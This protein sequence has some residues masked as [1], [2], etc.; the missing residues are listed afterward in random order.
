MTDLS[1]D[2]FIRMYTSLP[3]MPYSINATMAADI[4]VKDTPA[5]LDW[6]TK[7]AVTPV[8]NQGQCGRYVLRRVC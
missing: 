1:E 4:S 2:E 8:K 5:A 6:T 7:N 3:P